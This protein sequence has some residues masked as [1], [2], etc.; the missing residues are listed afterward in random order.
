MDYQCTLCGR[1]SDN[2]FLLGR[3]CHEPLP[4]GGLCPGMI[5][6]KGKIEADRKR[7]AEKLNEPL[8]KGWLGAVIKGV[9][10]GNEWKV[11]AQNQ[12]EVHS[13][14]LVLQVRPQ[15]RR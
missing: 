12:A 5:D 15:I 9:Q 3:V 14:C 7:L 8:E 2:H 6:N 1:E 4:S 10:I 11:L 13:L